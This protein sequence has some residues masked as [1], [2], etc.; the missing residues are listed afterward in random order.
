MSIKNMR[1]LL[2]HQHVE[3]LTLIFG[4][5]SGPGETFFFFGDILLSLP[6]WGK[7]ETIPPHAVLRF[8]L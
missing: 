4:V 5:C 1:V 6:Q 3:V 7:E 2:S 8:Y